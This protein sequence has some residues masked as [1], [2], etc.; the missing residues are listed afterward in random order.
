MRCSDR[1]VTHPILT[2]FVVSG[3]HWLVSLLLTLTCP[4]YLAYRQRLKQSEPTSKASLCKSEYRIHPKCRLNNYLAIVGKDVESQ[5]DLQFGR[6]VEKA[7]KSLE[8][9]AEVTVSNKE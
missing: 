8:R 9:Y 2:P 1:K 7:R 4:G 3:T 5:L 6:A